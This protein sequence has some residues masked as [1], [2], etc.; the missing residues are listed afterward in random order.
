M[1]TCTTAASGWDIYASATDTYDATRNSRAYDV[2]MAWYGE[3]SVSTVLVR[4]GRRRYGSDFTANVQTGITITYICNG[5]YQEQ[6]M[7]DQPLAG[8]AIIRSL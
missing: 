4:L 8:M 6:V 7:T 1:A 5:N 3:I 2:P